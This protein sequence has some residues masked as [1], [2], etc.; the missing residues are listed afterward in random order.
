[1]LY[2]R[3]NVIM[4]L[5]LTPDAWEK[6]FLH[7]AQTLLEAALVLEVTPIPTFYQEESEGPQG[8]SLCVQM[9]R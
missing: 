8:Q 3:E 1:M 4:G 9:N 2:P 7:T 5:I 6:A